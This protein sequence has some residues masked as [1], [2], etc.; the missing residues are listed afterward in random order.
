[1]FKWM[2]SSRSKHNNA[3]PKQNG[4]EE[5]KPNDKVAENNNKKTP[6]IAR[7]LKTIKRNKKPKKNSDTNDENITKTIDKEDNG[8]RKTSSNTTEN[9]YES[10]TTPVNP[11]DNSTD[12]FTHD[13]NDYESYDMVRY[14]IATL[15]RRRPNRTY[16]QVSFTYNKPIAGESVATIQ[17]STPKNFYQKQAEHEIYQEIPLYSTVKNDHRMRN[18]VNVKQDQ[19]NISQTGNDEYG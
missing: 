14:G 1:M 16:E 19:S 4:T 6:D 13:N 15:P 12:K 2:K 3:E 17:T 11:S 7:R 9:I 18:P 10:D 5:T 8:D